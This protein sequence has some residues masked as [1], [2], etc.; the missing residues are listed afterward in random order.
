MKVVT[1]GKRYADI[2]VYVGIIAY[3]ELLRAQGHEAVAVTTATLNASVPALVQAWPVALER[4][5]TPSA[6]DSYIL[7]DLSNPEFFETFVDPERVEGVLDHH[8][9]FEEYWHGRI[10]EAAHIDF[11]GA[12]CTLVYEAWKRAGLL[13]KMTQ[14]SAKLLVCGI[15]DN[16]LNLS[17]QV[18]SQRDKEAYADLM[19]R[20]GLDD[21]WPARYFE[22]CEAGIVKDAVA[23]V[24]DDSKVISFQTF[25]SPILA[26]Q[27]AVW[28]GKALLEQYRESFIND[29]APEQ[30]E[31]VI[32]LISIGEKKSYFV[33]SS[34]AVQ[35]W[36]EE[37]L[38][39]KFDGSV[40]VADRVWLRKEIIKRDLERLRV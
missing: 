17:A 1:A 11:I 8:P 28:N 24:R 27:V 34:P 23:A 33:T 32:N 9:G 21:G 4:A 13:D 37:L 40:T 39:V 22:A 20:G 26:G 3:A 10:G 25:A 35:V 36:L 15:L 5:Y 6:S 12:A 16:T 7:I 2:D 31:R 38:E 19:K 14:V 30:P 29:F 18:T